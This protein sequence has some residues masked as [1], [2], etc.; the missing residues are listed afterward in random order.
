MYDFWTSLLPLYLSSE[1]P[2]RV[3]LSENEFPPSKR[4]VYSSQKTNTVFHCKAVVSS[5]N[6][7]KQ[8]SNVWNRLH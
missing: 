3:L 2:T 1:I 4:Q 6:F 8:K 5:P 7:V